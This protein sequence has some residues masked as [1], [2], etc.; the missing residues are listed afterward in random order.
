MSLIKRKIELFGNTIV[1]ILEGSILNPGDDVN[2]VVSTDDNYLTMASGVSGLLRK[3]AGTEEYVREAQRQCPV[4][5][6]T[7]VVTGSYGLKEHLPN[8]GHVLHGTV[9]DYDTK[10]WSPEQLVYRATTSCLE[11]AEKLA[12]KSVRFPAFAT[13]SGLLSMEACARQM[14]SAIKVYLAQER[15]LSAIHLILYLPEDT[16]SEDEQAEFE[17]R[18]KRFIAEANL[19]LGVPYDPTLNIRQTRD[20]YGRGEELAQIESVITGAEPDKRNVVILGGPQIGKRALLDQLFEQAQKA[21][22]T[23][24]R[25]RRIVKVTFGQVH[26]NT[27]AS[28]IYRKF[29]C[30]LGKMEQEEEMQREIKEAYADPE[31]DC[32]QFL[33]FLKDHSDRYPEVVFLVDNLPQLLDMEGKS[34]EEFDDV[35]A[36]WDDIDRMEERVRFVYTARD[37]E[38]YRRLL[39]RLS[40]K[41][42]D[43]LV[44]IHLKCISDEDRR[45]WVDG[46]YRRYLEREATSTEQDFFEEEAGQHPYLISLVGY[47]LIETI[48]RDAIKNPQHHPEAYTRQSLEPFFRKARQTIERPRRAFFDQLLGSTDREHG[49][50]LQ[51]LAQAVAIEEERELL[52]PDLERD[53]PN[54][55]IRWQE[56]QD[57]IDRRDYLH[58]ERLLQLEATGHLVNADKPKT[59]QFAAKPLRSHVQEYYRAGHWQREKDKPKD[60]VISLLKRYQ[61]TPP[62][63]ALAGDQPSEPKVA[64]TKTVSRN[65]EMVWTMFRSRGATVVTAQK[66]LLPEIKKEFMESFG[67][68]ISHQLHPAR[69]PAPGVFRDLEEVGSYILTQFTTVTIKRHIQNL[70]QGST[71]LLMIDDDLKDIPW[72]LMLETAYAGEIPFQVGRSIVSP[73]QPHCIKLPVGRASRAKALLIGDPTD[74]LQFAQ[75]EVRWLAETLRRDD[76][77]AHPDV[78][79]GPD[80]CQRIRLLNR[81]GS[82]EYELIHYSGHTRFDGEQSAWRLKDG[83]IT[84][85]ML[86]NAL[87]MAPPALVFSSSCES[88]KASE[89]RVIR[90]ENQTFDLPS[91]FLQAGVEAYIGTLWEVLEEPAQQFAE[92]FYSA[93]LSTEYELG[94][95]LRRAKW[96]CKQRGRWQDRI[97]WLAFVLYGDPHT[98]LGDLFPVMCRQED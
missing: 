61:E 75:R 37:D 76:R 88:A 8:V 96:A 81:L 64:P 65:S 67:Q 80:D 38:Q 63:R 23:L 73:R 97:H 94:E 22:S 19:V 30:A 91:A 86:T 52:L 18:N 28:F 40:G 82:G 70:P 12:L 32:G 27:P 51:N 62:S 15:P 98:E 83:D 50:D 48:K 20:F 26:K 24:A 3:R 5:A 84:T 66:P 29:L 34:A 85:D 68:C 11:E 45:A 54:A 53:D 90:Y 79:I 46:L 69:H 77:F 74:E 10:T 60:M 17:K 9:I 25:G 56:L 35:R 31:M 43:Q 72:E 16:D 42:Q 41:F 36:F 14:C 44:E 93:L 71:V 47:A 7:V 57:E 2:A 21:G 59:A 55:K 1:Q 89:S 92:E 4:T 78:M 87:Q 49:V 6:G 33:K 13:G 39:N 95:C 58:Q